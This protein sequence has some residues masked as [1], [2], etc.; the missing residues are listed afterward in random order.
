MSTVSFRTC[1]P[2]GHGQLQQ[3]AQ[4]A[5]GQGSLRSPD[6]PERFCHGD[7]LLAED[8]GRG[9]LGIGPEAEDAGLHRSA[10]RHGQQHSVPGLPA[11]AVSD[12]AE[13]REKGFSRAGR[14]FGWQGRFPGLLGI[15][16]AADLFSAEAGRRRQGQAGQR[17]RWHRRAQSGERAEP[18]RAGDDVPQRYQ[19]GPQ[20]MALPARQR[21]NRGMQEAVLVRRRRPAQSAPP[22][23]SKFSRRPPTSPQTRRL[24]RPRRRMPR[25]SMRRSR[26]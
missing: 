18:P 11:G 7:R 19:G 2:G 1:R 16:P 22:S 21:G 14:G 12:R 9:E 15:Q 6:L 5:A 13:T 4:R 10:V 20:E 25:P 23:S 3:V 8:S 26:R 24:P 17:Y